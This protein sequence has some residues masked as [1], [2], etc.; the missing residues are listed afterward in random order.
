V[1]FLYNIS[2]EPEELL[3]TVL[4]TMLSQCY[5]APYCT[6]SEVSAELKEK[7]ESITQLTFLSPAITNNK[8]IIIP[9]LY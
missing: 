1:K 2:A 9:N 4:Q 7:M 5:E 3:L 8:V 6:Q